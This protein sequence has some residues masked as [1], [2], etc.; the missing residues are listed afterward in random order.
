[1]DG[2][3]IQHAPNAIRAGTGSVVVNSDGTVTI[4]GNTIVSPIL[5]DTLANGGVRIQDGGA[6]IAQIRNSLNTS[7]VNLTISATELIM[8][9]VSSG[10]ISSFK[11]VAKG[12]GGHIFDNDTDPVKL[13]VM[14]AQA[15]FN[16]HI[17]DVNANEIVSL[18]GNAN[19]VNQLGIANGATTYGPELSAVGD[20][21]NITM[22]LV[23][24]GSGVVRLPNATWLAALNAAGSADI[25][26]VR[27]DASNRLN[28]NL[29]TLS[30]N[31]TTPLTQTTVGAAGAASA[32]PAAPTG[33]LRWT[34]GT[35][36]FVIP[37]YLQA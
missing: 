21:A 10:A 15:G 28:L 35:T 23:P 11:W 9:A 13:H 17:M 3:F 31:L 22:Y 29:N 34:N 6:E 12:T 14:G 16:N 36:E 4:T 20:D 37:Y 25:N 7:G 18:R 1:M 2:I 8:T 5:L 24:K 30:L 19:A 26:T 27:V 33:Y 32:L